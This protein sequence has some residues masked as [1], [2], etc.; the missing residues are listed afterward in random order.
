MPLGSGGTCKCRVGTEEGSIWGRYVCFLFAELVDSSSACCF[1]HS[2]R[3]FAFSNGFVV[4]LYICLV[5]NFLAMVGLDRWMR[6][7]TI[8][9]GFFLRVQPFPAVELRAMSRRRQGNERSL[10]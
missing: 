7:S 6:S 8:A 10:P 3:A 2:S 1:E 9:C 4:E 5:V